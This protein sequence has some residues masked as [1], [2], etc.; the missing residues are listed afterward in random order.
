MTLT[1]AQSSAIQYLARWTEKGSGLLG[2][3][4]DIERNE[5]SGWQCLFVIER[6]CRPK[7][8]LGNGR[9]GKLGTIREEGACGFS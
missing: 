5:I 4:T 2:V 7:G 1:T 9:Q 8:E 6:P 3:E